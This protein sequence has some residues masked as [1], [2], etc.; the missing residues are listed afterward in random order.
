M[1]T[2]WNLLEI[3]DIKE[4]FKEIFIARMLNRVELRFQSAILETRWKLKKIIY[5]DD[6]LCL[7]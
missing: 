1:H 5:I 3:S 7:N 4:V 6:F 2:N